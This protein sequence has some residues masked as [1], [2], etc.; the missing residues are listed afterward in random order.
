MMYEGGLRIPGCIRV[1]ERTKA[2]STS[3]AVCSTVDLLPT[4]AEI[5]GSAPPTGIDGESLGPLLASPDRLWPEREIYFVRREGGVQY[6]GMTIQAIRKGDM[7]LVRNL[8]TSKFELYDLAADPQETTDLISKFPRLF[9]DLVARL[10]Y[11]E[12]RAGGVPW[13][14]KDPEFWPVKAGR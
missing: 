9:R 2:G 7:K 6:A 14:K 5:V 11:H 13:Q 8:P 12:Q 10:Q 1:P 3:N 4:L